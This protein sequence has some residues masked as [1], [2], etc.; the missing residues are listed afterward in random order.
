[1]P[2]GETIPGPDYGGSYLEA[3]R[4]TYG[5]IRTFIESLNGGSPKVADKLLEHLTNLKTIRHPDG[6]VYSLKGEIPI[7]GRTGVEAKTTVEFHPGQKLVRL[8]SQPV[9]IEPPP[10]SGCSFPISEVALGK[11]PEIIKFVSEDGSELTIDP[12]GFFFVEVKRS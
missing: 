11:G 1:M 7:V 4:K 5:Q 3:M 8:H 2:A 9:N 6:K 10:L 12:T